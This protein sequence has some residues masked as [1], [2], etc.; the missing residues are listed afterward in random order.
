MT[1]KINTGCV[2]GGVWDPN[3]L[4]IIFLDICVYVHI[5]ATL[6]KINL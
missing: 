6:R 5:F 4:D 3:A 1:S 2:W